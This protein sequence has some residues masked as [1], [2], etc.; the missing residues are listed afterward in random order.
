[1][2][3]V[4]DAFAALFAKIRG[5]DFAK[6]NGNEKRPFR[7]YAEEALDIVRLNREVLYYAFGLPADSSAEEALQIIR[8]HHIAIGR[9]IE[10]RIPDR[11]LTFPCP[12]CG[13]TVTITRTQKDNGKPI[14]AVC[15]CGKKI[16]KP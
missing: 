9:A 6:L 5:L 2:E 10:T 3:E 16:T 7:R 12:S 8:R 1:M 14:E 13:R 15:V 4:L 11:V